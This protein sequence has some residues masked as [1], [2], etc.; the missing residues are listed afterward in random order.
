MSGAA[1]GHHGKD[2]QD[3][4]AEESHDSSESTEKL[5]R[6]LSAAEAEAQMLSHVQTP[7]QR[8]FAY[9]LYQVHG[10]KFDEEAEF[11]FSDFMQAIIDC[12]GC[13]LE[14]V[15]LCAKEERS[16]ALEQFCAD[17]QLQ[18]YCAFHGTTFASATNIC[19][20]GINGRRC[21]TGAWGKGFYLANSREGTIALLYADTDDDH[22]KRFRLVDGPRIRRPPQ[23]WWVSS[24]AST[25]PSLPEPRPL[26][27]HARSPAEPCN[28]ASGRGGRQ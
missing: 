12:A 8:M 14:N 27:R 15:I 11:T 24:S 5:C 1:G 18:K 6:D 19:K 2:P 13:K 28:P 3:Q 26:S 10:S 20:H 7:L 9:V 23:A 21:Q 17:R 4:A 22:S 16:N 25:H